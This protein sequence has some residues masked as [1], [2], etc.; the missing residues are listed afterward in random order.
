MGKHKVCH[1]REKQHVLFKKANMEEDLTRHHAPACA[2]EL[3]RLYGI[4]V[5]MTPQLLLEILTADGPLEVEDR[6]VPSGA[7]GGGV[8]SL[9]RSRRRVCAIAQMGSFGHVESHIARP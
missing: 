2:S 7:G 9:S 6:S 5:Q 1:N 8:N 3:A 4:S